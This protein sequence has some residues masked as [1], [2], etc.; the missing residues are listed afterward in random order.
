MALV[1]HV[2]GLGLDTSSA[3]NIP[4]SSKTYL[5]RGLKIIIITIAVIV[6]V[7]I[8]II[9][10]ILLTMWVTLRLHFR[11]KGYVLWQYL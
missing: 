10:I 3:A 9:I 2:S 6:V 7:I 4:A 11:L 5:Q 1:L 8:I